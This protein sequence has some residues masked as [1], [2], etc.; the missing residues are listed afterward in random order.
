MIK[1]KDC[2]YFKI[3]YKPIRGFD[4][5][6]ACCTRYD[7]FTDFANQ[8]KLNRLECWKKEKGDVEE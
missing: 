4:W 2:K 5:G 6:K 3:L 1:C 7:L 8:S